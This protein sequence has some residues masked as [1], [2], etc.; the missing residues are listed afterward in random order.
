MIIEMVGICGAG[1]STLHRYLYEQDKRY[2]KLPPPKKS[3]YLPF[4]F[5][6][7]FY[8]APLYFMRY[9]DSRFFGVEEIRSMAYLECWLPYLKSEA[10][11]QNIIAILDPGSVYWLSNLRDFDAEITRGPQFQ[12]WWEAMHQRWT[13]AL[14]AII[15]LDA[16]DEMLYNRVVQR[17]EWHEVQKQSQDVAISSFARYRDWYGKIIKAVASQR[18]IKI[19]TYRTDQISTEQIGEQV[20]AGLNQ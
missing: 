10:I 3:V 1:K 8:W 15:W 11:K 6:M 9:R 4:L 2:V 17:D 19:Y 20:L 7:I 14:D 5:K 13:N 12:E 16:P 18:K